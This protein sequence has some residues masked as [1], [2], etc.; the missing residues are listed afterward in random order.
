MI[1][2]DS[3]EESGDEENDLDNLYGGDN[4]KGDEG[5]EGNEESECD[6][7]DGVDLD[8]TT[9]AERRNHRRKSL[10]YM[11][12]VNSIDA[13]LD[14]SNYDEM[15]PVTEETAQVPI[16]KSKKRKEITFANI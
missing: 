2:E 5:F 8:I 7:N 1:E 12:K 10:T 4:N 6:E 16:G 3:E 13:S 14:E 11:R 15:E 9:A